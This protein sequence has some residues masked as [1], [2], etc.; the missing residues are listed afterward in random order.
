[1]PLIPEFGAE[2][3]QLIFSAVHAWKQNNFQCK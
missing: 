3:V 2:V 1:V